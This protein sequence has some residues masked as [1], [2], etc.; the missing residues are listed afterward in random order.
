MSE[1]ALRPPPEITPEERQRRLVQ[2]FDLAILATMLVSLGLATLLFWILAF[3]ELDDEEMAEEERTPQAIAQG[4]DRTPDLSPEPRLSRTPTATRTLLPTFTPGGTNTPLPTVTPTATFTATATPTFTATDVPTPAVEPLAAQ[5]LVA[6]RP[7][8]IS[9]QAQPGDVLFIFDLGNLIGETTADREG[10]WSFELPQ[11]LN[12]GEHVLEVVAQNAEGFRSNPVPV[13][14]LVNEPPTVTPTLTST[15]TLTPSATFTATQTS[16]PTPTATLTATATFTPTQR[17]SFTATIGATATPSLTLT[18]TG[19]AS[20]PAVTA[21]ATT[22]RTPR[23][24]ATDTQTPSPTASVTASPT[25]GAVAV[26]NTPTPTATRKPTLTRTATPT[27][28]VTPSLTLTVSVTPSSSATRR[29]TA[30]ATRTSSA[31][32]SLT[33]TLTPTHTSTPTKTA[34]PTLTLTLTPTP[35]VTSSPTPTWTATRPPTVTATP[36]GTPVTPRILQPR[37]GDTVLP[38]ALTISGTA[39]RRGRVEILIDNVVKTQVPVDGRG[40]WTA[41]VDVTTG[42]LTIVARDANQSLVRS[43]SVTIMVALPL[44]PE[45]GGILRQQEPDEYRRT[46]FTAMVALLL[47]SFGFALIFAGRILYALAQ[48]SRLT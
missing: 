9:G 41:Q 48:R 29:N 47:A 17:P 16:S 27:Q 18:A 2:R 15:A 12:A 44:P 28:T 31:T 39:A 45:S 34:S 25:R 8:V 42:S 22:S 3:Q 23:P 32:P 4:Q 10:Q 37:D 26:A 13:S 30:T 5:D 43:N 21:T 33:A 20:E 40:L 35:T 46:V 36:E 24:S 6:G 11:G 38:G 19:T 7:L 1:N 14:I